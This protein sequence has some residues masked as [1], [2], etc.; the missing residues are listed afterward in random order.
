MVALLPTSQK[1]A[2]RPGVLRGAACPD[3]L[4]GSG[5]L[6]SLPVAHYSDK[7]T[8]GGGVDLAHVVE[9]VWVAQG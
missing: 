3:I 2:L 4:K 1:A 9:L 6:V 8:L 7:H 5:A